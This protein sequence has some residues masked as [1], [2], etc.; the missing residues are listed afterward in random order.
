VNSINKDWFYSDEEFQAFFKNSLRSLVMKANSPHFTVLAVSDTYL[1]LMHKERHELIGKNL[2][3]VFPGSGTDPNEKFSVF[4]SFTRVIDAKKI[5]ELPTFKYE[6]FVPDV[7]KL[8]TQYW[9]NLNEPIFDAEGNVA[10]IINTTTNITEKVLIQ[11]AQERT[12]LLEEAL[13]REQ[14]LNEELG[15]ANEELQAM[16]EELHESQQN[17]SLLNLELEERI[18]IRTK[19]LI[20]SEFLLST[21]LA[22]AK[23]G[24]WIINTETKEFF[25]SP[26]TKELFGYHPNQEMPFEAAIKQITDEYRQQVV[27]AIEDAIKTG[28]SYE[29]EYQITGFHD[30]KLRWVRATGKLYREKTGKQQLFSGTIL[31]ITEHKMEDIRKNGFIAIV[32][33]ELKT[34]LTSLTAYVQLLS[35]KIKQEEDPF[36]AVALDKAKV[37]VKKMTTLINSFLNISQLESGRIHLEKT[38]FDLEELIRERVEEIS[39]TTKSHTLH[40]APCKAMVIDA[41][42]EKIG[43]VINNL[44]SNAVK[45]SPK[46]KYI[47]IAC[48]NFN[49]VAQI[50]VQDEGV[51]IMPKDT[52]RIFERFYRVENHGMKTISG[53]GI[54]LYLSAEIIKQHKGNIG[55]ESDPG[56]GSTFYFSLPLAKL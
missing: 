19:S 7:G 49:N 17:L 25:P 18:D 33:H 28:E 51:G 44:L 29:I 43:Q 3:D 34:P 24:T 39:L 26:R 41:D 32:S 46:A 20:E 37:Q 27:S 4:S 31:D 5:D 56:K 42:R 54:G 16:N 35:A 10:Y 13:N 45:Y 15:V 30:R 38:S 6:I 12:D 9:S 36:M 52:A 2:F 55:V 8:E 21:A 40:F 22:S 53:F 14:F 11:Q 47:N 50:R 23:M 48:N 1:N